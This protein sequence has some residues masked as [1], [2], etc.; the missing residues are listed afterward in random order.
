[1]H[2]TGGVTQTF[3]CCTIKESTEINGSIGTKLVN[4]SWVTEK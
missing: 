1:M 3:K 4:T 2:G